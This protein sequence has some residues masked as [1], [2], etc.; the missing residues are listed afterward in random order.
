MMLILQNRPA[1]KKTSTFLST[2]CIL[3][4]LTKYLAGSNALTTLYLGMAVQGRI[5]PVL[6]VDGAVGFLLHPS[7]IAGVATRAMVGFFI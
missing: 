2:E 1:L 4:A 5:P 3:P 6:P 7:D